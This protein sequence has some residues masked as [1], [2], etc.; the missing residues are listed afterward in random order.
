MSNS[1]ANKSI[2]IFYLDGIIFVLPLCLYNMH[3][4][5]LK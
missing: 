1:T 2:G 5:D 3:L 4:L